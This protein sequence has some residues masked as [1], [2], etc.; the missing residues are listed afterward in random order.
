MKIITTSIPVTGVIAAVGVWDPIMPSH[1]EMFVRLSRDAHARSLESCAVVLDPHPGTFVNRFSAWP[2]YDDLSGKCAMIR[3]CGVDHIVVV[4]FSAEDLSA[5]A[6][7]FLDAIEPHVSLVELWLGATQSLGSGPEGSADAITELSRDRKFELVRL[8]APPAMVLGSNVRRL[9]AAGRLRETATYVGR[10]PVRYRSETTVVN[11]SWQPGPYRAIS[12]IDG[13]LHNESLIV[14]MIPT[15]EYASHFI[16][17]DPSVDR[18]L[19]V[20]GPSDRLS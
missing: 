9:L 7:D 1:R 10:V 20:S 2:V 11:T 5:G 17:P 3:S 19:F 14:P 6:K 8:P 4:A 13:R 15:N 12:V 18:L 16:W